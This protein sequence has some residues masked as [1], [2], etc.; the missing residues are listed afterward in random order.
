MLG[1][2]RRGAPSRGQALQVVCENA[3]YLRVKSNEHK[4][5]KQTEGLHWNPA[6]KPPVSGN[7]NG[8]PALNENS[9]KLHCVIKLVLLVMD[10]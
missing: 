3:A 8:L 2:S 10:Q 6:A 9:L 4:L 7:C 1:R 5:C